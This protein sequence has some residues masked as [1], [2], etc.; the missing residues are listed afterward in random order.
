MTEHDIQNQ[1]REVLP[2]YGFSVF[3]G[4]VGKVKMTDG[5]YF[6]TGLPRGWPD[7]MA[8]KAGK[9]YF[10]EVKGPG[11]KLR[12]EQEDFLQ[13]ARTTMG[14]PAGVAR[15]VEDALEICGIKRAG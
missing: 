5:R 8:I 13:F 15:S 12:P 9:I 3:R 4:N 2:L 14:C 7:L 10:V 11:G 6:D 1:I